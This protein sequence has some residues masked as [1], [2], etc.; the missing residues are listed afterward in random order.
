MSK[1]VI[2]ARRES[3]WW[4]RCF[5]AALSG[6]CANPSIGN[7]DGHRVDT[8]IWIADEAVARSPVVKQRPDMTSKR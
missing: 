2:L 4:R 8:A 7:A 3:P 6:L 1:G 5:L